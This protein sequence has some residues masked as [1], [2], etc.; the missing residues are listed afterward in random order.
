M[1]VPGAFTMMKMAQDEHYRDPEALLMA[2]AA[3]VNEELRDLEK[4]GADVLQIDEPFLQAFPAEAEKYGVAAIDRALEGIDAPTIVHL[5]FGYAYV[6]KDKP[7]GYSFLPQLKACR[8][9]AISIEAAQPRLD[10]KVLEQLEGKTVLYGVL[11]LGDARA[12][13][14]ALVAERL[15][16]ALRHIKPERLVVAPDCGMKYLSRSLAFAKM[17]A[18]VEGARIVR[19]ELAG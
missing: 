10:P 19:R 14:P 8:A 17:Q 18:M 11:D 5:C 4:A 12:E 6:M 9:G 16:G 2:Y 3:V 1:T 13:T 15:R 7:S